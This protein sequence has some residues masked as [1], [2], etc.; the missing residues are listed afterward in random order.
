PNE[1]SGVFTASSWQKLKSLL[2]SG[3]AAPSPDPCIATLL[4]DGKPQENLDEEG[5]RI[6]EDLY[7]RDYFEAWR[8]YLSNFSTIKYA[9]AQDA[10]QKLQTL[11]EFRSP[12]LGLFKFVGEHTYF[13]R[14]PSGEVEGG[15]TGKF[16][17]LVEKI[18]SNAKKPQAPPTDV[19]FTLG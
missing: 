8:T 3:K 15:I 7:A 13:P 16:K 17:E 6:I 14:Q 9:N 2:D 1:L 5:K 10:A 18:S 12:L 4:G 19:E 11:S